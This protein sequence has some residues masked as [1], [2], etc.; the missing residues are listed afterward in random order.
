MTEFKESGLVFKFNDKWEVY[1]LDSEA[2]YREKICRQIPGTRSIDFIGFNDTDNI[3]LFVEVK[4][5]RGYGNRTNVQRLTGENDDITIEVSQKVRDSIA[6]IVGGAR[7]S[8]NIRNVWQKYVHHLNTNKKM[9][10][11]AWVELDVNTENLLLRAKTNLY[12]RKREL[13]KHLTWLTSDVQIMN[14]KNYNNE[15]EGMEVYIDN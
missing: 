1:Q 8:T 15:V 14:T 3:L 12:T 11:I 2:D 9:I 5:F 4:S 10:V 6:T 13:R 7:N